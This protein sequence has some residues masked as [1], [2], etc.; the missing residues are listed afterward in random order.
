MSKL[1][2][3][4]IFYSIQG[5]GLW[6]GV[7]S[8][9]MRTFG[10]NFTCA[11]FGLPKGQKSTEPD[12]IALDIDKYQSYDDLPLAKTGC[13]SYAAWHNKFKHLSPMLK[14]D[15]VVN[16]LKILLPNNKWTQDNDQDVHLVITGGEP[17]LG[18]QRSYESLLKH[19]DMADLRNLTFETNG[20]QSLQENFKNFLEKECKAIVTWSVSPKLPGSGESW[21][22]AIRPDIVKSYRDL[23]VRNGSNIYLKFVVANM[24]DVSDVHL[25]VEAYQK[26][27]IF[28][29]VYLM[30][31]GGTVESYQLNN[32]QVAEL[33]M[34]E[35]WR[36][37]PRLQVDLF[38]NAWGT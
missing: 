34:K 20:T 17:L 3:S 33:A 1:K 2:I 18:W 11:G 8:V 38:G 35:G 23:V 26:A 7:P 16:R 30:P 10:C 5:E 25:A 32:K 36:Y 12:T 24:D 29:P 4:E 27:G 31:V 19:E 13:D 15:E 21:E 14:I 9:F 37:S 28:C 6:T 22:E